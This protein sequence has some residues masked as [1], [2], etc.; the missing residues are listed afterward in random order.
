MAANI[1]KVAMLALM[2]TAAAP[3]E[4]GGTLQV[5]VTAEGP[6]G[7][8]LLNRFLR[9]PVGG[10]SAR[11]VQ[12]GR[13]NTAAVTQTGKGNRAVVRQ[14]GKA[15]EASISQS[16]RGNRLGL[17]QFGKATKA[18]VTQAGR[19]SSQIVFLGGW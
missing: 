18:D 16:G 5:S 8:A 3:A 9:L 4:A 1:L 10:G 15:H 11:V 13:G 12:A 17:Y 14:S 7:R 2:L 6:E 19:R